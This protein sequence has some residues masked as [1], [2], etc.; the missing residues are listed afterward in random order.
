M[1]QTSGKRR[2][3]VGTGAAVWLMAAGLA[4][5]GG[6]ARTVVQTPLDTAYAVEDLDA[7]MAFLHSLPNQR[8]VSNDEGLHALFTIADETDRMRTYD[9]RVAEAKRR[10]WLKADF[11]EP[12]NLA[13]SR[14]T[15]ARALAVLCEI[16]GGV[17]MRLLGPVDRYALRELAALGIVSGDSTVNQPISGLEFLGVLGKAQDYVLVEAVKR[18]KAQG[19]DVTGGAEGEQPAGSPAEGQPSADQPGGAPGQTVPAGTAQ[20]TLPE[21]PRPPSPAVPRS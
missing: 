5:A 9:E 10:N 3:T 14:G 7:Q 19:V 4:L 20:P 6:C 16:E 2:T 21:G 17:M 11:E 18:L 1:R 15:L 8:A 12:A 13:M